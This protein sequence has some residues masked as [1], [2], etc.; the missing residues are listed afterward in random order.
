MTKSKQPKPDTLEWYA[1]EVIKL[2]RALRD[3]KEVESAARLKKKQIQIDL[4]LALLGQEHVGGE[5]R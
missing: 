2:R 3:A 5:S 4:E 1:L